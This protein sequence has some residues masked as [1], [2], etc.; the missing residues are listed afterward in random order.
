MTKIR[1]IAANIDESG[2]FQKTYS[3]SSTLSVNVGTERFYAFDTATC[4]EINAYVGTA[5]VGAA[6]TFN[7]KKNGSIADTGSISDGSNSSTA[8]TSTSYNKGDYIT[9]DITQ[10]GSGTAGADLKINFIFTK[11]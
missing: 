2:G 11:D 1:T 10:I 5:P 6:I 3:Y 4:K 7:V 9:V 8:T